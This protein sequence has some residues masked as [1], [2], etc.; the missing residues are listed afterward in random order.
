MVVDALSCRKVTEWF[1]CP[2]TVHRIFSL[3]GT[4]DKDL[5]A[6]SLRA[7]LTVVGRKMPTASVHGLHGKSGVPTNVWTNLQFV[8]K[9]TLLEYL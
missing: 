2:R 5:F 7:Q 4:L 8:F 6:S 9:K 1:L 3:F